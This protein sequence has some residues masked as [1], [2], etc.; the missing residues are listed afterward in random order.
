M[1]VYFD[2]RKEITPAS[3]YSDALDKVAFAPESQHEGGIPEV[4]Q[5]FN[6]DKHG[7]VKLIYIPKYGKISDGIKGVPSESYR[8]IHACSKCLN[9]EQNAMFEVHKAKMDEVANQ[10]KYQELLDFTESCGVSKRNLGKCISDIVARN[11]HQQK[12]INEALK[13]INAV[14]KGGDASNLILSGSV[15]TGKTLIAGVLVASIIGNGKRA[16]IKTVSTIIRTLKD[17]WRRDSEVSE[18]KII[19]DYVNL[20]L[21]VIDEIGVQFGSDTEKMF[22]FEIIDGRYNKMKPTILISN[23]DVEGIKSLIGERCIDRL[24][25]DGG[26]VIAF[27]YSSQRGK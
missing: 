21:L 18:Q 23:L 11:D 10:K 16:K 26:K 27:D 20:D 3:F 25:E 14:V 22:I 15:G 19:D 4:K 12:A 8:V 24:R 9:D 2:T 6:C 13:I 5:E 17:S 1:P 7:L